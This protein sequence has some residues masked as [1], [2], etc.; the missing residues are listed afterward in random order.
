MRFVETQ[1]FFTEQE[2]VTFAILNNFLLTEKVL[3][4]CCVR[5]SISSLLRD[6]DHDERLMIGISLVL[7]QK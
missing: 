7:L 5:F 1:T 4:G 2:E 6:D 3:F